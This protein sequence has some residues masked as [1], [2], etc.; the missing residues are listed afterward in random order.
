MLKSLLCSILCLSSLTMFAQTPLTDTD[1]KSAYTLKSI[2]RQGNLCHDPSIFIDSI[3]NP[4][5]PVYYIYGSHLGHGK[6]TAAKNYQQ[7][8]TWGAYENSTTSTSSLFCNLSGQRVNYAKAYDTHAVTKVKNCNGEEVDFGNFN[9]HD[10]Q[11]SDATI[12]GNQWA[13]DVIWNKTMKKWCMYMSINSPDWCS[14]IVCLTSDKPEGPWMYQG[15]VVFSGFAGKWD[16]VGFTKTADWKQTDFAIATGRTSLPSK[17][18]PSG[19]YGNT[20]PNCIDPC[21]FY[22][23]ED[24]LWMSY[25]S[26][27]GGI[28]ML[29]L[30]KENG[31]RDYEYKFPNTG[32]GSAATSDEYFGKKI[33]GGYYS[34]G[35]ASYIEKIGKY[36]YLFMSYGGLET[37][38]GYQM[39]IFRSEKPDGPYKDP[40]GT[41]AIY[42]SYR[43]NYSAS[44]NDGRG[45]LLMGGYK[46]Q[47]MPHAEIAQGHNSA[48]TDHLG[49]SF[50]VYH[51]RSTVG[52][53]GHE[54]RVHQLFLNQDGWIMA[55]PF[56]FSGE[57]ITNDDIA[58]KAS[59]DDSEI[60]GNYQ[61]MR[62]EYNQN[63]ANLAYEK[64]VD[65][66]LTADGKITGSATGTWT[67]T[68]GTDF[69][70]LTIAGVVYKGVLVR[71]T[72]DYSNIK[73]LCISA[74]SSSSGSITIGQKTFTRQQN[75]WAVKADAKAA[76]KYT[77]DRTSAPF[78]N[79]GTVK[80]DVTFPAGLLGAKISWTSSDESIMT[81]KGIVKGNGAVTMTMNIE[82]DGYVYSKQYNITVDAGTI[83]TVPTYYPV[84]TSKTLTSGWWSNF[85]K[86]NYVINAGEKMKFRFY[87]YS[88]KAENWHNWC[89]YGASTTHGASGYTE[90]FGLRCDNW[91]NTTGSNTGC[92]SDFNWD[93]FKTDMAGSLVDM[94][95]E[96]TSGGVFN[97]KS[98]ITTTGNTVYNYSYTKTIA[99]KPLQLTLFFVNEKSYI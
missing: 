64:P 67:R 69:I 99:A 58:T 72:I 68:A 97:M 33:A 12:R 98:T 37:T 75:V 94:E 50:V 15:P 19:N 9:A 51:T 47:L 81:S 84:S 16:H 28:F 80:K 26:W 32:S 3:S 27:S 40:Y 20:W 13:A 1:L 25:G 30:N 82:K 31:L 74:C 76:I 38:G 89:L 61:F 45:M 4:A 87:N 83:A 59:I 55:A 86:D 34:S 95:V 18:A 2:T 60:A 42:T 29:R 70:S 66:E 11:R 49:R 5:S 10:W 43:M 79:G 7:W 22:D 88:G 39:R 46:W 91:D 17:Y 63:T 77:Y 71:Q 65:I 53:E 35:E 24:N 85:S 54:V 41:S 52:H 14:V 21:V 44:A 90:Y 62:H 6:T 23:D 57:T 93:T 92:T 73:A 48:M 56:E 96:Y 8:T 36:Y 78:I